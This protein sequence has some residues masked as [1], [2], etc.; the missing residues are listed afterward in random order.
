MQE[1]EM[2]DNIKENAG[3]FFYLSYTSYHK[4]DHIL[5]DFSLPITKHQHKS[6][7]LLPLKASVQ[8]ASIIS[9][10][11]LLLFVLSPS[12]C[13][14]S[15]P[16]NQ[17]VYQKSTNFISSDPS[18]VPASIIF[19]SPLLLSVPSPISYCASPPH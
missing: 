5:L 13:G 11:P 8:P 12:S 7:D 3:V 4:G 14:V 17:H 10:P 19:R 2:Q 9:M 16:L 6:N 18:A 15:P 1:C